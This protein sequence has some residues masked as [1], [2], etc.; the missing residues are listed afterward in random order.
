MLAL[1]ACYREKECRHY[2]MLLLASIYVYGNQRDWLHIETRL[3]VVE[4]NY[5]KQ[6]MHLSVK[7]INAKCTNVLIIL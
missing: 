7:Q 3:L 1:F 2:N 6:Y 5:M 4:L